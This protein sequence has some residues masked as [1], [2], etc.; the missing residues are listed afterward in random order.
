LVAGVVDTFDDSW[1]RELGLA[2]QREHEVDLVVAGCSD[3]SL[4][5]MIPPTRM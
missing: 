5:D 3:H 2:E 4:A 1:H